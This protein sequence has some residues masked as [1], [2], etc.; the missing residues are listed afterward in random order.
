MKSE[1]YTVIGSTGTIGSELVRLLAQ[2]KVAVRGVMRNFNRIQG[3]LPYVHWVKADIE[4]EELLYGVLAGTT[5]LFILSGNRPGFSKS[6]IQVIEKAKELGVQHIVKLSALGAT[7]RSKSG[8]TK[9]HYDVEQALEAS[10]LSYTILRPHAF[11]QNWLSEVA[12]TVREENKIYAAVGDGKVPFIDTRD[13]AAVAVEALLHPE[14]HNNKLYVLTSGKAFS[15]YDLA[16]AI[17]Q[18]IQTE[19]VYEPLSMEEMRKRMQD[20]GIQEA[21]IDGYLSLAA[22]Q[23]AGGATARVSPDV[24]EVLG[25]EPI[26]IRQFADDFREYFKA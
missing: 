24:K 18:A 10:G 7:S 8:L 6:Q 17:S 14:K 9:E 2:E 21:M 5:R 16:H 13:I 11:M 20:E 3:D 22:H 1:V 12:K 23:K 15:Y 19:V 26:T 25:R 4:R